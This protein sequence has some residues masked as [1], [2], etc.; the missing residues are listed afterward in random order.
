MRRNQLLIWQLC[1]ASKNSLGHA[2]GLARFSSI[3][4][5]SFAV[6]VGFWA[7]PASAATS[8]DASPRT[9]SLDELLHT[10]SSSDFDGFSAKSYAARQFVSDAHMAQQLAD[11]SKAAGFDA[12]ATGSAAG[13]KHHLPVIA[14]VSLAIG[15]IF[16]LSSLVL[17]VWSRI[18]HYREMRDTPPP[19]A[20][21][22]PRI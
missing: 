8:S 9:Q 3:L 4:A 19:A 5:L 21:N 12:T 14:I 2:F 17:L 6:A 11:D 16:V 13:K 18:V 22:F 20:F 7:L 10:N 15:G 1:A